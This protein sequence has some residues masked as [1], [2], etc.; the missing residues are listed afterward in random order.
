MWVKTAA[1]PGAALGVKRIWV[2]FS[3]KRDTSAVLLGSAPVSALDAPLLCSLVTW[4]HCLS[5]ECLK[6]KQEINLADISHIRDFRVFYTTRL[7]CHRE[8]ENGLKRQADVSQPP[9]VVQ[10]QLDAS[11]APRQTDALSEVAATEP[12]RQ[13]PEYTVVL[14]L[15]SGGIAMEGE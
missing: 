6:N 14:S 8:E 11:T 3:I 7:R 10:L 13:L 2:I 4:F 5:V 15:M 9:W 12:Q 1:V